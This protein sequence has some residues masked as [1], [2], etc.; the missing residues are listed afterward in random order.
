M[1]FNT[2]EGKTFTHIEGKKHDSQIEFY[3]TDGDI[4]FLNHDQDCCEY[5][6][7]ED[8]IGNFSDLIGSP[9]L[10]ATEDSDRDKHDFG[11]I[12]DEDIELTFTWTFYNL[13][14]EKGHVTIRFFGTSNG[15]YSE[16]VSLFKIEK[17]ESV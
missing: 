9:I 8:I 3:C 6:F 4:F 5:V 12:K 1:P 13:S 15:Y 7:V 11:T 14:T 16:E 10:R 17:K 2:L